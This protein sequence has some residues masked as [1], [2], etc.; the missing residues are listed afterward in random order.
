MIAAA[1][2]S[3][4]PRI[5][6]GANGPPDDDD[7]TAPTMEEARCVAHTVSWL[8]AKVGNL[9]DLLVKRKGGRILGW[10]Y[11][12]ANCLKGRVRQS[13]QAILLQFNRKTWGE[14]QHRCDA[15][16]EHD[17]EHGEGTLGHMIESFRHA[18]VADYQVSPEV[19]EATEAKL[20]YYVKMDA[21]L[22]RLEE[23]RR[24]HEAAAVEAEQAAAD[25]RARAD[26]RKRAAK[27]KEVEKALKGVKGAGAIVAEHMGPKKLAE[28]LSDAALAVIDKA[29]RAKEKG[30]R[31]TASDFDANGLAECFKYALVVKSVPS[32]TK[33]PDDPPI[34]PTQLAERVWVKA[35]EAKRIRV[36]KRKA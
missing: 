32:F 25:L 10:R 15:W 33:E 1:D 4:N 9:E 18:I 34:L 24:E 16:C 11:L 22:R 3:P 27:A 30:V 26:E 14:N 2:F 17:D 5:F 19:V 21:S 12:A 13:S 6:I 31:R 7:T 8:Q 28:K 29:V 20:K 36:K 35:V 23:L